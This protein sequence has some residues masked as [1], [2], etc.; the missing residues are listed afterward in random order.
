MSHSGYGDIWRKLVGTACAQAKI[1]QATCLE[2]IHW[3]SPMMIRMS[4][5]NVRETRCQGVVSLRFRDLQLLVKYL[6]LRK[7]VLK[8]S[9]KFGSIIKTR[10]RDRKWNRLSSLP[11][12]GVSYLLKLICHYYGYICRVA[13]PS[14]SKALDLSSSW[15]PV[16]ASPREFEPRRYHCLK[17]LIIFYTEFAF[18]LSVVYLLLISFSLISPGSGVFL[19]FII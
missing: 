13:W 6:E 11:F 4:T 16:D 12:S 10:W 3:C 15:F 14:W 18:L 2:R 19:F 17:R 8:L 7:I 9:G 5:N 1:R